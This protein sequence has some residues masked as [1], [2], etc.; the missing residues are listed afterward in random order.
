MATHKVQRDKLT[1][2]KFFDRHAGS[3]SGSV[4]LCQINV[5]PVLED[6]EDQ[7]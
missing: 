4:R 7:Q 3:V 5:L 2:R 1:A 6:G